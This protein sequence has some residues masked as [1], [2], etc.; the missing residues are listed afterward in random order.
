MQILKDVFN[1]VN[2]DG[3]SLKPMAKYQKQSDNVKS[4]NS[5]ISQKKTTTCSF[6][7]TREGGYPF[8]IVSTIIA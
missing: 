6:C 5:L 3:T 2:Q 4:V 7:H 8:Y 1:V